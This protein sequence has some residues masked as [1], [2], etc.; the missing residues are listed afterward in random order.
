[1]WL[2]LAMKLEKGPREEGLEVPLSKLLSMVDGDAKCEYRPVWQYEMSIWV[3]I[4]IY[5]RRAMQEVLSVPQNSPFTIIIIYSL[6][7]VLFAA[8]CTPRMPLVVHWVAGW[9]NVCTECF[10][11]SNNCWNLRLLLLFGLLGRIEWDNT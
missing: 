6:G 11:M 2:K 3:I 1:M 5:M 4:L 8:N 10:Y 7:G 9:R